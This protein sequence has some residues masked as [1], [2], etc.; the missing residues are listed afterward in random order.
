MEEFFFRLGIMTQRNHEELF[1]AVEKL[2]KSID[3]LSAEVAKLNSR[4]DLADQ[5]ISALAET[6]SKNHD[7]LKSAFA[8]TDQKI[9]ALK[10]ETIKSNGNANENAANIMELLK[11]VATNQIMN[12]V[13]K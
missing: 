12:L 9:S 5:K 2:Q 10:N 13:S 1:R 8:A 6:S 11:L 4:A 3:I 7:E